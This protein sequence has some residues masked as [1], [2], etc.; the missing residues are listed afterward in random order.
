MEEPHSAEHS[1]RKANKQAA[2]TTQPAATT[3]WGLKQKDIHTQVLFLFFSVVFLLLEKANESL[4]RKQKET[5]RGQK[6]QEHSF[7]FFSR[8]R[9]LQ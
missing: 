9:G 8:F 6:N 5:K 3:R 1:K 7:L 2:T 4:E